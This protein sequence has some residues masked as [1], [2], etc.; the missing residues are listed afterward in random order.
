MSP[1]FF[2]QI[3][4]STVPNPSDI[5]KTA[6]KDIYFSIVTSMS[7]DEQSLGANAFSVS[8]LLATPLDEE[9]KGY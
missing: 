1:W 9:N 2:R 4:P 8:E 7:N 3:K 5:E 6:M